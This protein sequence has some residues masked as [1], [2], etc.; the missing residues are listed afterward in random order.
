MLS[1]TRA[2]SLTRLV[3]RTTGNNEQKGGAGGCRRPPGSE[4]GQLTLR[5]WWETCPAHFAFMG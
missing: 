4:R 2:C 5:R 1:V 3:A